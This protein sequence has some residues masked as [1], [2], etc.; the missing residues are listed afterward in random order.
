MNAHQDHLHQSPLCADIPMGVHKQWDE[1]CCG[2]GG[3]TS[4]GVHA[5]PCN[6]VSLRRWRLQAHH[7]YTP[8]NGQVVECIPPCNRGSLR[9]DNAKNLRV[10]QNSVPDLLRL[11]LT[12]SP[13]EQR[14]I[15]VAC[16]HLVTHHAHKSHHRYKRAWA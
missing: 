9:M 15:S 11:R 10:Y 12:C 7:M 16:F 14:H 6:R 13:M 3:G 2:G 4:C 8:V 1:S 5:L